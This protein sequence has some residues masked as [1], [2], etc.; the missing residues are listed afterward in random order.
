MSE[1]KV[2]VT[3]V[4]CKLNQYDSEAML[5]NL[6]WA[7]YQETRVPSEADLCVVNTCAVTA[8]AER[9]S[10]NLLRRISREKSGARLIAVGCLAERDPR[11]LQAI[12]GVGMV[13]GNREKE[14]LLDF[15][16]AQSSQSVAT[17]EI[18]R[19]T[20]WT[21]DAWTDGLLGRARAYLKV[22]DGCNEKC[23][24]CIVP[25]L[26]GRSRS[27]SM[28]D[29]VARAQRLIDNGFEEIVLTGVN[30]ASY[31]D[32]LG[33]DVGLMTLLSS[34]EKLSG[35][36]RIRLGSI[37]PWG[38]SRRLIQFMA[39]SEKICPHLHV[40]IQSADDSVL[41]RMNRRYASSHLD[42]LIRFAFSLRTDWGLG[43]DVIVGFPGETDEQFD[44]TYGFLEEHPF[45]YL[46]I[47]PFSPRP[48]TSAL[49]LPARVASSEI[50]RRARV[51]KELD[52]AK[53][54]AFRKKH[55]GS[56]QRVI[57]EVRKVGGTASGYASNYLRVFFDSPRVPLKNL[58]EIHVNA[59][60]PQGVQ[61]HLIG[62]T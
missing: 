53:R 5:S 57:P 34:L 4:G 29:T 32:D 43:A 9:K 40:P 11:A 51:L 13:L 31:G 56:M 3:T 24:Y 23:T 36:R 58:C 7:G 33:M 20:D 10:R 54:L 25:Q 47:F 48:G 35:L 39:Q 26:R 8:A 61:G 41:R 12:E 2:F 6:R 55:I 60:H 28:A 16:W 42:E 49:R 62:T 15:L 38:L 18:L 21:D 27:R 52:R 44:Q 46:H 59:L 17:G 14:H 1:R 22:Q 19:V 37:E 45:T 50:S 30:L